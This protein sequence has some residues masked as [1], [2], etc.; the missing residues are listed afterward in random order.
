MATVQDVHDNLSTF[1][2]GIAPAAAT[3]LSYL[4]E[5]N[6]RAW[7]KIK[8]MARA[9]SIGTFTAGTFQYALTA[10]TGLSDPPGLARVY[11][12]AESSTDEPEIGL[13]GWRLNNN[14]GSFSITFKANIVSY[15]AG[16]AFHVEYQRRPT[17][18]TAVG[19]TLE[20][21]YDYAIYYA[22]YAY[23]RRQMSETNT[24]KRHWEI[25]MDEYRESA[26]EALEANYVQQVHPGATLA[27]GRW[28]AT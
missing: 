13:A 28:E 12:A 1:A 8:V 24:E 26:M 21:P 25:L 19:D 6:A 15:Y 3:T 27:E 4:K 17:E 9:A 18:P 5:A 14:A 10:A 20:I 2:A 7:P 16:R 11:A 22:Q 23:C